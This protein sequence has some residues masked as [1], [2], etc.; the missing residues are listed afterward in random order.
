VR[1]RFLRL[2]MRLAQTSPAI[3]A[4]HRI[5]A[6]RDRHD[7]VPV[8][9]ARGLLTRL[10]TDP[11]AVLYLGDSALAWISPEDVDQR[12]LA[13]MVAEGLGPDVPLLDVG[14]GGYN[15][16]LYS[17]YL[18]LL[19]VTEQR[20]L[21][22]VPLC[23][24]VALTALIDHP[25]HGRVEF[26]RAIEGIDLDGPAWR[27]HHP[28]PPRDPAAFERFYDL[29]I[30]TM[31]GTRTIGEYALPLRDEARWAFD[32]PER[33]KLLYAYHH[34]TSVE[35]DPRGLEAITRMAE[36]LRGLGCLVVA[37]ETPVPVQTGTELLGPEFEAIVRR[38]YD[39]MADAYR[40]GMGPDATII[41]CGMDFAPEEF[42][43]PNDGTEHFNELGRR[44]LAGLIAAAVIE[45]RAGRAV[46]PVESR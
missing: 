16:P 14:G 20:P 36:R 24:R 40:A 19:E 3:R 12:A 21:V 31:L 35:D 30:N 42:I 4:R 10:R 33:V 7:A 39:A 1:A 25:V 6:F 13:T 28:E 23:I 27:V 11:P 18:R 26:S 9:Q 32:D 5:R 44:H 22:I 29:K 8:R 34:A 38:N 41:R 15:P 43:D 2:L 17:A 37:Y 45:A 46:S